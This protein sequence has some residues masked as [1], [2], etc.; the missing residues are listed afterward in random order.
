MVSKRL[1]IFAAFFAGNIFFFFLSSL[2][3]WLLTRYEIS[4]YGR[5]VATFFKGRK[6]E[7]AQA[8]IDA[9][10]ALFDALLPQAVRFSDLFVMPAVGFLMGCIVGAIMRGSRWYAGPV[11]ALIIAGPVSIFFLVRSEGA[12][13]FP[14]LAVFLALIALGGFAGN[15][16]ANRA[17]S[18]TAKTE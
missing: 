15:A 7:E 17:A 18:G 13:R 1:R 14:Y 10:K 6:P 4:P 5:F 12:E 3:L 8:A 2:V 9:N 16:F 11:W